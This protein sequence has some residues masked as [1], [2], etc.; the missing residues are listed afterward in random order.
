MTITAW[1]GAG[2]AFLFIALVTSLHFVKPELNPARQMISQYAREPRGWIMKLAFYSFAVSCL[3]L[4]INLWNQTENHVGSL[5]LIVSGIGTSLAGLFVTDPPDTGK[6]SRDGLLHLFSTF[7]VIPIFPIAVA[8]FET[9]DPN[10]V[11]WSSWLVWAGFFGFSLCVILAIGRRHGLAAPAGYFQRL[12]IFSYA[13][14]LM[15]A[16]MKS[17]QGI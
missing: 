8:L 16:A 15:L 12:M 11:S 4:A 7:F 13:L 6:R 5:M 2:T 9:Q 10:I 3:M 1:V 17:T 14:W